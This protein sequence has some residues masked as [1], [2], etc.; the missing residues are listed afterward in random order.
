MLALRFIKPL[1]VPGKFV[2]EAVEIDALAASDQALHIPTTE[3]KVPHGRILRNL[4][5]WSDAGQRRIDRHPSA[6]AVGV[7]GGDC[8]ADHDTDI[9]RHQFGGTHTQ[10]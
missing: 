9:V 4:I 3:V 1:W 5:P 2:P 6:D 7:G 8:E 10:G